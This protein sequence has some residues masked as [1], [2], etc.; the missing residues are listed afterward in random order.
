MP[1]I[2]Q[3]IGAIESIAPLSLQE[4][5]DNTGMLV[6]GSDPDRQCTCVMLC[7]DVTPDLF[8]PKFYFL[9]IQLLIDAVLFI[10]LFL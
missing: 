1:S 4:A 9:I 6:G 3:I 7:V 8:F 2:Q 5:W 10:I